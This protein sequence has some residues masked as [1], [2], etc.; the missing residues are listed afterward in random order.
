MESE[1]ASGCPWSTA[2]GNGPSPGRP[3]SGVVKQ[4][5]SSGGSVDTTKTRSGP[6]RVGM[7]SGERPSPKASK[8]APWPHANPPPPTHTRKAGAD[9]E[10][11]HERGAAQYSQLRTVGRQIAVPRHREF[12]KSVQLQ[13]VLWRSVCSAA[14]WALTHTHMSSGLSG[15]RPSARPYHPPPHVHTA[16]GLPRAQHRAQSC[17]Q[18]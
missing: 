13:V 14:G 7:C 3:T 17:S 9:L 5:K 15:D 1:G 11:A 10:G 18:H 8:P 2:Q 16:V 4:D 12:G 6:Q